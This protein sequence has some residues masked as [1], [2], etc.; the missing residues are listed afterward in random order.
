MAA[1]RSRTRTSVD[2]SLALATFLAN[3]HTPSQGPPPRTRGST[4]RLTPRA[5][6]TQDHKTKT[7]GL[8]LLPP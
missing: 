7:G 5:T 1:A 2:Q 8:G 3:A 6:R 4:R